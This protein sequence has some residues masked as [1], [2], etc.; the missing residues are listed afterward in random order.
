M[1]ADAA[2]EKEEFAEKLHKLEKMTIE[3]D[4]AEELRRFKEA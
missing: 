2:R 3:K 1:Q 4:K